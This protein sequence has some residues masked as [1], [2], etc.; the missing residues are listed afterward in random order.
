MAILA[1]LL[2]AAPSLLDVPGPHHPVTVAAGAASLLMMLALSYR[3]LRLYWLGEL[4]ATLVGALGFALLGVTSIGW[5][6]ERPYSGGFWLVHLLDSVGV[7]AAC[8]AVARGHRAGRS[9]T[10]LLSPVLERDPLAAL[11]LGLAPVV[12]RFVAA[13]DAKDTQTR[14]HVV[15]VGEN[16]VRVGERLR[17]NPRR[18]RFLGLAVLLHDIGKLTVEDEILKKP[19]RLTHDEF[20][21]IKRHT[22]DGKQLLLATGELAPA[23]RFVRSHHERIDGNGYPDGLAG[24]QIPLE[25]RIIAVADAYDA[26]AHTRPYRDGRGHDVATSILREHS[27]SQWD[28]DIVA[29]FL[30]MIAADPRL[31][32]VF[33]N[34]GR[35]GAGNP[36]G[37]CA[38][39][40]DAL[41]TEVLELLA[42]LSS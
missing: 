39:C 40:A 5:V 34:V 10:T 4:T 31:E 3:Q 11:E 28:A 35:E 30:A 38:T 25:S 29:T 27:G 15:R 24:E 9:V 32:Y 6:G 12:R 26:I 1:G 7:L 20:D 17:L 16:A 23:A 42:S 8:I 33:D 19:A 21:R 41:S 18:L 2:L 13:L 36:S 37:G 22:T 14:D